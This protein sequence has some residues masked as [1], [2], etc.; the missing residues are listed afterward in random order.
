MT[1][2][3]EISKSFDSELTAWVEWK[4]GGFD[5]ELKYLSIGAAER[6]VRDCQIREWDPK[7]HQKVERMDEDKFKRKLSD[8]IVGWRGLTAKVASRLVN[9][10]K[11]VPEDGE[12]PCTPSAKLF[13]I[14]EFPNFPSFVLDSAKELHKMK[15]EG[16][17]EEE[18]NS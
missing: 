15:E 2:Q 7:S 18:K 8:L 1:T 9:L 6:L 4:D 10:K 16:Q 13:A 11:D 17:R 14:S 5:V 3:L 12:F